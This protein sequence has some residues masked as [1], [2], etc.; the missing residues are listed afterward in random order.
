MSHNLGPGLSAELASLPLPALQRVGQ[1]FPRDRVDDISGRV[2]EELQR[3]EIRNRIRPGARVAITAGSR[4]IGRLPEILAAVVGTL[5][6]W[7]ARPFIV[8]AMGS[9]GGAT[10][11]GQRQILADYGVTE[12]T[13][14]APVEASMETVEIGRVL[15][16]VPVFCDALAARADAIIPLNRIKPHTGYRGAIE[17]G[18]MK[19]MAI[20]LGKQHGAETLHSQGM[21]VFPELIPAVGECFCARL[22]VAFGIGIVENA[23][24]E[25]ARIVA[26][27]PESLRAEEAALLEEARARL[28][29]L[30]FDQV[31]V[32]VVGVLGKNISGSGMDPNVIGRWSR[33]L[34][35]G[36]AG[37]TQATRVVVL[38]VTPESHGNAIGT[39]L[40]DVTT[41]R[42]FRK[43]DL[44]AM[45][46]NSLT[47]AHLEGAKLPVIMEN[48]RMAIAAAIKSCPRVAPERV[49]LAV[50]RSTLE[51]REVWVSPPLADEIELQTQATIEPATPM[52]FDADGNLVSPI[53]RHAK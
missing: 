20:G 14:G 53:G 42:L 51:L 52:V 32:L 13:V 3:P 4:G 41:A 8:P 7:E 27:P 39:G 30:P 29:R 45:Y 22:P 48:D 49:R 2:R 12:E 43:L 50:I 19:M 16:D 23:W 40:A 24:E 5:Q 33:G 10:A 47:A 31:D 37:G 36:A 35:D 21:E 46:A 28:P 11:E 26:I 17:S 34:P 15:D 9:H 6:S 18:V 44:P 38:D 25:P 1:R